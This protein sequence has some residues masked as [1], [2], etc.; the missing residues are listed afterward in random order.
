MAEIK[1][2]EAPPEISRLFDGWLGIRA[3]N[4][5]QAYFPLQKQGVFP[6][7]FKFLFSSLISAVLLGGALLHLKHRGTGSAY[8]MA[9]TAILGLGFAA[10]A[11]LQ[12][13]KIFFL[14]LQII[15]RKNMA[16]G[17][18]VIRS[19][20]LGRFIPSR[21]LYI[22]W[23][24]VENLQKRGV[25]DKIDNGTSRSSWGKFR[26]VE[27]SVRGNAEQQNY[28]FSASE[29]QYG[30]FETIDPRLDGAPSYIVGDGSNENLEEFFRACE[31]G[32]AAAR[33]SKP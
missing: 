13:R 10:L 15:G 16:Y 25:Y 9:F 4:E 2:R 18:M 7:I 30:P 17:L 22:P 31:A 11:L 3:A 27:V 14:T 29:A 21:I 19:G 23:E 26:A 12:A 28:Y 33:G 6:A 1:I 32:L 5:I 8:K 24:C 20:I